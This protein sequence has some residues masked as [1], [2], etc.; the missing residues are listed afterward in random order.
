MVKKKKN[1]AIKNTVR[2]ARPKKSPKAAKEDYKSE[3]LEVNSKEQEYDRLFEEKL[4]EQYR[5]FRN[6]K[7]HTIQSKRFLGILAI[8]ITIILIALLILAYS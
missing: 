7:D 6:L 8:L 4:A 1:S 3:L 5:E 2:Y